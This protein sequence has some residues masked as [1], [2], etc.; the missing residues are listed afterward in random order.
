MK[1]VLACA[2][3]YALLLSVSV[4]W[5]LFIIVMSPLQVPVVLASFFYNEVKGWAF[6]ITLGQDQLVNAI[7]CGNRDTDISG[8]V[9]FHAQRGSQI[10]LYMEIPINWLFRVSHNHSNHCR[11]SVEHDEKYFRHIGK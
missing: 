9:G 1:Y 7:H 4:W 10:A 3:A 8:R 6:N 2:A 11:A 5:L